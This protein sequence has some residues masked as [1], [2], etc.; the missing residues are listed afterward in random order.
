M[1][2]FFKEGQ[3]KK[4]QRTK[5][6]RE[7]DET[8]KNSKKKRKKDGSLVRSEIHSGFMDFKYAYSKF[9]HLLNSKGH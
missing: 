7:M 9:K 1:K 2:E 5:E 8:A 6:L 3:Q 4:E